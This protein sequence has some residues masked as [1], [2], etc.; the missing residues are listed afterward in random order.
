[1]SR[2]TKNHKKKSL[3]KH[4]RNS[5]R[6]KIKNDCAVLALSVSPYTKKTIETKNNEL[7]AVSA[8]YT[9]KI[10]PE[11][12]CINPCGIKRGL[13][14][15]VT[16]A[17]FSVC[18]CFFL[19]VVS[20]VAI[21]SGK[22]YEKEMMS[23]DGFAKTAEKKYA[24]VAPIFWG[25][26]LEGVINRFETDKKEVVLTLDACGGVHGSGVDKELIDYLIENKIKAT[27]FIN[28]RWLEKNIDL[29]LKIISTGL[30]EVENHGF[31]HSPLSVTPREIYGIAGTNGL[32]QVTY[33]VA[34]GGEAI[35]RFTGKKPAFFRSGTAYYDDISLKILAD[36]GYRAVAFSINADDGARL[37]ADKV[38]KRMMDAK[39]GDIIIAHM[40]RPKGYTAE[41]MIK[42]IPQLQ[43][44]GFE[45]ITLSEAKALKSEFE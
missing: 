21:E 42:A 3:R 24:S 9:T 37:S 41:G 23:L 26:M 2:I 39:G 19:V 10:A 20:P 32:A 5:T 22:E 6:S 18:L 29:F 16:I 31:H 15:Y 12:I 13:F 27:L 25:E 7:G 8:S 11:K 28:S 38:Y 30:F 36:M 14:G 17:L 44:D 34:I 35:K 45:F 43:A 40:N 1:M 33:E 4:G